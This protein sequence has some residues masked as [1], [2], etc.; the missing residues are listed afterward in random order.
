MSCIPAKTG[1]GIDKIQK[2]KTTNFFIANADV[3]VEIAYSPII[4]TRYATSMWE[5]IRM[6][7]ILD[8]PEKVRYISLTHPTRSAIALNRLPSI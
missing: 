5:T 3:M 8:N 2:Q 6:R 1:D 7:L 4:Q